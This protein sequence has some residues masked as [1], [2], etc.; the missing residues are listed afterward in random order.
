M[1]Q[2]LLVAASALLL[3]GCDNSVKLHADVDDGETLTGV[4]IGTGFWDRSGTVQLVG[5]RG[6]TCVG[7]FTYDNAAGAKLVYDCN[8]GES[9]TAAS[10]RSLTKTAVGNIG[11]RRVSIT[12]A[13]R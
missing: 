4:A 11:N 5:N 7:T 13:T 9:G 2:L 8:N 6:T 1:K 12:Y 3:V 10:D